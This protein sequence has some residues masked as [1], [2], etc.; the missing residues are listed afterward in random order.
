M[1]IGYWKDHEYH[2]RSVAEDLSGIGFVGWE[3]L[4]D[5]ATQFDGPR[6]R[7]N[8]V[9]F[10]TT[11]LT[12]GRIS[13]VLDL[14]KENFEIAEDEILVRGMDLLKRYRKTEEYKEWVDEKPKSQLSRLYNFDEEEKKFWRTRYKTTRRKT[15]RSPFTFPTREPLSQILIDWLNS[16]EKGYLFP[17]YSDNHLSYNRV[18][19][20][21]KKI[22][23]HSSGISSHLYPHFLRGQRASCLISFYGWSMEEMMEWMGWEELTTA[24]MY[25]KFGV[26]RLKMMKTNYPLKAFDLQK[27][28][29]SDE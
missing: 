7:R 19:H 20:I 22:S 9:L 10:A 24:R 6:T 3:K 16:F 28:I 1:R 5:L 29:A 8:Q 11:F 17:G 14:K 12:G 21:F 23:L 15:F 4:V 13:E 25:A 27:K 2:R 26:K 18:Y